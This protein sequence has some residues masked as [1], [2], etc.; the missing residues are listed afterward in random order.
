MIIKEEN[1]NHIC[2]AEKLART[3]VTDASSIVNA[4]RSGHIPKSTNITQKLSV[5]FTSVREGTVSTQASPIPS[6][7]HQSSK[8]SV[9]VERGSITSSKNVTGLSTVRQNVT[10]QSNKTIHGWHNLQANVSTTTPYQRS[11]SQPKLSHVFFQTWVPYI[12]TN[13][14]LHTANEMLIRN[15]YSIKKTDS[16]KYLK[17]LQKD[18]SCKGFYSKALQTKQVIP[19]F[20]GSCYGTA[21]TTDVSLVL[22]MDHSTDYW[23]KVKL[24]SDKWGGFISLALYIKDEPPGDLSYLDIVKDSLQRFDILGE[25]LCVHILRTHHVSLI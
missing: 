10:K 22:H 6:Q 24:I 17:Q 15:A 7:V 25:R 18:T 2:A 1:V 19:R 16:R 12:G 9:I 13:C 14:L 8:T 3:H 20:F 11:I 23:R 5:V 4:T 21:A